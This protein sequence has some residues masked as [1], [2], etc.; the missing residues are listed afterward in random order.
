MWI[1]DGLDLDENTL[2]TIRMELS[3]HVC[4]TKGHV[5]IMSRMDLDDITIPEMD[6]CGMRVI[7]S[8]VNSMGSAVSQMQQRALEI[9]YST[10]VN[11]SKG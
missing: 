6:F 4:G 7:S 1:Q 10:S 8:M 3:N 11:G 5:L 2:S 9:K